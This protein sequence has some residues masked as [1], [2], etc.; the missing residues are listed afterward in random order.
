MGHCWLCGATADTRYH[1]LVCTAGGGR[2]PSPARKRKVAD[3]LE[4]D[5]HMSDTFASAGRASASPSEEDW[6]DAG[7]G[8]GESAPLALEAGGRGA[9]VVSRC[10]PFTD[11]RHAPCAQHPPSVRPTVE[12]APPQDS[13]DAADGADDVDESPRGR[14]QT[15]YE[16]VFVDLSIWRSSS[17]AQDHQQ[18]DRLFDRSSVAQHDAG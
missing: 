13:D 5:A 10:A 11:S 12:E 9:S 15:I 16:T 4:A 7:E 14:E 18:R 6:P 3:V 2:G 17:S 1:Y 8:F